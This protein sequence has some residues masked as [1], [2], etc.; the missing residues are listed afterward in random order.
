M[1]ER[2]EIPIVLLFISMG[3]ICSSHGLV[4]SSCFLA[5]GR[6]IAIIF[7]TLVAFSVMTTTDAYIGKRVRR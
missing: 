2:V 4:L 5:E 1:R 6:C 3:H 7:V